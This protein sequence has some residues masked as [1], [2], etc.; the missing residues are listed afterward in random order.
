MA[1]PQANRQN[2]LNTDT[3][4]CKA[5]RAGGLGAILMQKDEYDNF[6]AISY[7]SRQLKD[8]KKLLSLPA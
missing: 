4:I 2:A 8:H 3:T 6:Y 7:A 1:F 5:D